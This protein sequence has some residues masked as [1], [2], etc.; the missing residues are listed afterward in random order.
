MANLLQV[1]SM[2]I[3]LMG[4]R[5]QQGDA[6]L[7][8]LMQ[9]SQEAARAD[10]GDAYFTNPQSRPQGQ[11]VP[12]LQGDQVVN[13]PAPQQPGQ[14]ER[15]SGW[16]V[17]DRVLGGETITGGLD[18]ERARLQAEADRPVQQQR[19]M[20][21]LSAIE[22]PRERALFLGVGGQ[23]WQKNVAQ[24]YAPQ[25]VGAGASQVVA[26]RPTVEQPTFSESGD[27]ILRR[28]STGVEPVY[29]R[30]DPSITEQIARDK[31]AWDQQYGT[32]NLGISQQ[33]ADTSRM[34]AET[35][36]GNAGFALSPNQVR[37][38]PDGTPIAAAPNPAADPLKA[39]ARQEAALTTINNARSA[40]NDALGMVGPLST[41]A[42]SGLIP[43]NQWRANLEATADTIAA[44]LSFSE[45]QKM[46]EASPTGGALGGIAV[47]ELDLLGSTVASLKTSQSP[48]QFRRNLQKVQTH[49]DN[50][51]R[52]VQE[53]QAGGGQASTAPAIGAVE[54]GY[55]YKGG[56]PASP[57]SWERVR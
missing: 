17:L 26:G 56:D 24:Q 52:A 55:R 35:T 16:R 25:V 27:T 22:D 42:I 21:V 14:R 6:F 40:V 41:G 51:E 53:A 10:A 3:G 38:A 54:D 48:E 19:I 30:T 57:S 47:R 15:V 34:N 32:T 20:E 36:A 2:T 45:L 7:Q 49:L 43:G 4:R 13:V 31:L 1:P 39:A 23:D 9:M 12:T 46:R 44:N 11:G 37:Y 50:W 29:T 5:P 28:T 18:A 33:N 8:R